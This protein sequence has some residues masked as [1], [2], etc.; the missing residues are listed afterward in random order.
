MKKLEKGD[1]APDFALLDQDG[2]TVKLSDHR[3]QKV[4]LYFYPRADTP[5]CTRQ[6]CSVRDALPDL[7]RLG[8]QAFGISPDKSERQKKFD[9]KYGLRFPL[10][11]DLDYSVATAYGAFGEKKL[12][13]KTALGITRCA[14]VID[15][16][17]K[18]LATFYKIKPEDTVPK[19]REIVG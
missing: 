13:G 18:L 3:G 8:V 15:E 17:G 19:V 9:D 16:Q 11:S 2:Q 1:I 6:S 10:L 5:G 4:V 14:F 7:S 12:Y